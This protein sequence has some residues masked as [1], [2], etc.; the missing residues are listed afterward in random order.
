VPATLRWH[1][2]RFSARAFAFG[3]LGTAAIVTGVA[4]GTGWSA[5]VRLPVT[6]GASLTLCLVLGWVLP[7]AA[8]GV[9]VRFYANVR[10]FGVWGP[11]RREAAA[12]GLVPARDPLPRLDVLNGFLTMGLQVALCLV[13]FYGLL[14]RFGEAGIALA[15]AVALLGVL[16]FTW[17]R[18]LPPRDEA[19]A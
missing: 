17:Y 19:A 9:L 15:A 13:P 8:R 11:V 6:I 18:A 1:W 2:W 12:Q 16:W 4:L 7:P 14:W 5:A 3:V 10:P